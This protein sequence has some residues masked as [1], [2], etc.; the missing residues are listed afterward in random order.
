MHVVF[1]PLYFALSGLKT[2]VTKIDSMD[3]L[4][5]LIMVVAVACLS[6]WVACFVPAWLHGLSPHKA[7]AV[8][9]LM[10]TR[11]LMEL[12]VLNLG[13]DCGVLS[14]RIF[15]IMI[16]MTLMTTCMTSPMMDMLLPENDAAM[17]VSSGDDNVVCELEMDMLRTG[18]A[19]DWC[20]RENNVAVLIS[21]ETELVNIMNVMCML[22]PTIHPYALGITAFSYNDGVLTMT[23]EKSLSKRMASTFIASGGATEG[24]P[25]SLS[26]ALI[27]VMAALGM[28]FGILNTDMTRRAI[29]RSANL[30]VG[31]QMPKLILIPWK[32]SKELQR[33]F[34][35][36]AAAVPCPI[37]FLCE[38]G[39]LVNS[40]TVAALLGN[41][42]RR[43]VVLISGCESDAYVLSTAQYVALHHPT[44]RMH[45]IVCRGIT[46][47]AE[48]FDPNVAVMIEKLKYI[49]QAELLA[50]M[51][52]HDF[53]APTSEVTASLVS[54]A[55]L[56]EHDTILVGYSPG[57]CGTDMGN[58]LLTI[59][60]SDKTGVEAVDDADLESAQQ[61]PTW[62][63]LWPA[64]RGS[65]ELGSL[66]MALH[67]SGEK[68]LMVIHAPQTARKKSTTTATTTPRD[69][70]GWST[71]ITPDG[72]SE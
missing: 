50:E 24:T 27:T 9:V 60:S 4:L 40:P 51:S 65:A 22:S 64:G 54:E 10:N 47:D 28:R 59:V 26:A 32:D 5:C 14:V 63:P 20:D 56:A 17:L 52:I 31:L 1:L 18:G 45:I 15:T 41:A 71:P 61:R 25:S 19:M 21:D 43:I 35:G 72:L 6:K 58:G 44:T 7:A 55:R 38:N 53:T 66:G 2:D 48:I 8:A 33:T 57:A 69:D 34:R 39:N 29:Q 16:V 67:R 68:C 13:V 23:K 46:G 36:V 42:I 12:I 11:G 62:S 30:Y 3:M 49:I 37:A 70:G